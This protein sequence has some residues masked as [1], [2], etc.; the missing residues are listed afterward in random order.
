MSET[1]KVFLLL[2]AVIGIIVLPF[3]GAMI[4]HGG[5][6]PAHFFAYPPLTPGEKAPFNLFVFIGISLGFLA[7]VILYVYPRLFGFKKVVEAPQKT[8]KQVSL[9]IW[10]WAGLVMWTVPLILLFLQADRPLWLLNWSD[11]PIFWGFTLILDGIVY[12]RTGGKSLIAIAPK[13]LV[14][15]GMASIAG[16]MIFEYLNLFVNEDWYYPAGNIIPAMEFLVYAILGSSGLMTMCFEWFCLLQ[17]YPRLSQRYSNGLKINLP[18]WLKI[19]FLILAFGGMFSSGLFPNGLFFALWVCP[20]LIL[21]ITMSLLGIWT[22]FTPIAQG[23]WSPVLVFA[24]TYVLQGIFM[25]GWNYFSA[26]HVV[27]GTVISHAPAYWAY[28]LPYINVLHV[29]EMPLLG[30]LGYLPFSLYCWIFWIAFAWLLNIPSIF[31]SAETFA[32]F[33]AEEK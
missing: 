17:T 18:K 16:W 7:V 29:F 5:T 1:K 25:E 3:I 13:E 10:F 32:D 30:F 6:F 19:I 26:I 28:S 33:L 20:L 9:P 4:H 2:V 11:L 15:I 27:D 8:P 21:A 24:L 31:S 22:P 12:K 14:G 23:N